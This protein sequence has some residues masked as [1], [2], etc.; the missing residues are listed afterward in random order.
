[1]GLHAAGVSLSMRHRVHAVLSAFC[2]FA[3]TCGKLPGENPC[4][5]ISRRI[6]RKGE[7]EQQPVPNPFTREERDAILDHVKACEEEWYGYFLFLF[8]TGV[9]VGE[10]AG[11]R[12]DTLD[13]DRRRVKI[14]WNF[15]P[16][17]NADKDPKT[18]E[19]RWVDLTTDL[20]AWLQA[21]QAVQRKAAFRHGKAVPLQVFTTTTR[22]AR[23]RQDGNMPVVF[24]RVLAALGIAGH[25]PHDTRDTFATLHLSMNWDRKLDWVSKQLGHATPQTTSKFYYAYRPTALAASFADEIQ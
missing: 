15:S 6:K 17:D 1:V 13:W 10:A 19:R 18:H 22:L 24:A 4:L 20:L 2:A 16:A 9:R 12:W 8:H 23:M 7:E 25:T 11:L 5:D 14:A 3:K 21:W